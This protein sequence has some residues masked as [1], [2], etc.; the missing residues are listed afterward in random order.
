MVGHAALDRVIGVRIPAS[1]PLSPPY[2]AL[3]LPPI[4]LENGDSGRS[5]ASRAPTRWPERIPG[6]ALPSSKPEGEVVFV[7]LPCRSRPEH[8]GLAVPDRR[9][10][11]RVQGADVEADETG[12]ERPTESGQQVLLGDA[13]ASDA[14]DDDCVFSKSSPAHP[15][16]ASVR[17]CQYAS[18]FVWRSSPSVRDVGRSGPHRHAPAKCAIRKRSKTMPYRC[19]SRW[20]LLA[21]ILSNAVVGSSEMSRCSVNGMNIDGTQ[22]VAGGVL[23]QPWN[24]GIRSVTDFSRQLRPDADWPSR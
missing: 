5:A 8:V 11:A 18:R 9:R 2:R 15:A 12:D 4:V 17:N 3:A 6:G 19:S 24:C 21:S 20:C 10:R 22:C 13:S 14:N 7:S 1:Q 23:N 16:H